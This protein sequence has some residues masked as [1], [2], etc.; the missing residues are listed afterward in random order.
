MIGI[1]L[2]C[3][4]FAH[5]YGTTDLKAML[6]RYTWFNVGTWWDVIIKYILPILI[7]V[8]W[9]IGVYDLIMAGNVEKLL[10]EKKEA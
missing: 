9:I 6:N 10:K 1:I 7:A 2:Q 5:I 8:L 3:I 4:I